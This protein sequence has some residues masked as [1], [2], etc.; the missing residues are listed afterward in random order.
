MI[1]PLVL[2]ALTATAPAAGPVAPAMPLQ[3]FALVVGHNQPPRPELPR[4]RYGDDDAIRWAMLLRTYGA[5]VEILTALDDDSQRLYGDRLPPL[6]TPTRD[7]LIAA[8]ERISTAIAAARASGARTVFYFVYAGHGDVENGEGYVA[9]AGGRLTR[10]DLETQIL[11]VSGADTNHVVVDACR[12]YYFVYDRGPGGTREPWKSPYFVSGAAARFRNTGF[13]LASSSEAPTHEW[14]EFQSGIFSH[15]LR[16]GLLGSADIDNDARIS[17]DELAAF[18]RV[19]N[20]PIRN[21]KYRP[22]F[23]ARPP[24]SGDRVFLDLGDAAGGTVDTARQPSARYLLEDDLGVRWA[25]LHPAHPVILR[26]PVTPWRPAHFFFRRW[27]AE[28]EYRIPAGRTLSLS[29]QRLV[30]AATLAR[31]AAHEAFAQLFAEPFDERPTVDLS[32]RPAPPPPPSRA[33]RTVS[34][35]TLAAGTS[36]LLTSGALTLAGLSQ[37]Q[38]ARTGEDRA[39]YNRR[40]ETMSTWRNVTGIAGAALV[41]S[42][43]A[44][45]FLDR[46]AVVTPLPGGAMAS[47]K[48]W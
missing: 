40:I 15:E 22:E 18:V 19:A 8:M 6:A 3:R 9:L 43:A 27:G 32:A 21:A 4:L 10:R 39:A 30:P 37:R 47:V 35:V 2:A 38:Q 11:A 14:E 45:F 7:E 13:L 44:M 29:G 5:D 33:L 12:S 42:G 23:V 24:A 28:Q 25:D 48:I 36:A 31:G 34:W 17:Y 20:R 1:A 41:A 16:S 46:R 26:L